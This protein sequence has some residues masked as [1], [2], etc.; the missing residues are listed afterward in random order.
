MVKGLEGDRWALIT[1][2]HQVMV[3]GVAGT[4]LLAVLLDLS[5]EARDLP[6]IE[7]DPREEPSDLRLMGDALT[8]L[9]VDPVEVGR[10]VQSGL[11]VQG[12]A[13]KWAID[14]LTRGDRGEPD[15]TGLSGPVSAR[16]RWSG[17]ELDLSLVRAVREARAASVSDVVLTIA[18]GGFRRLLYARGLLDS[19]EKTAVDH[20]RV[21]VPLPISSGGRYENELTV[22]SYDLPVAVADP[23]ERL[24]LI[25]AQSAALAD[26]GVAADVL[27]A[28]AGNPSARLLAMGSR[29]AAM[30]VRHQHS[31]HSI[32]VNVPGPHTDRFLLGRRLLT[33]HPL[34]PL[35]DGI[36]VSVG[37]VSVGDR[38]F[39]GLTGD[40]EHLDDLDVLRE[41]LPGE[42][43]ELLDTV[44]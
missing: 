39:V 36:R 8:D 6:E 13:L 37:A 42:L 24:E 34:V 41:S 3:D 22:A 4:P 15:P 12:A 43:S 29:V 16:R 23:G 32:I 5:P 31:Y 10:V 28:L 21:A 25:Q 1:K 7:W 35:V 30:A 2:T 11:R 19:V 18:A 33:N 27:R 9:A 17:A 44:S 38:I 20:V 26:S 14:R 40:P